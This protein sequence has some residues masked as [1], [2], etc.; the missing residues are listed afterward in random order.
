MHDMWNP[1]HGCLKKSEGCQNCYVY[2]FDKQKGKLG[3]QIYRT[4]GN[5]DYP[6]QKNR[7]GSYKVKSG[8]QLRVCMT[9]DFFLKEADIWRQEA[10]EIIKIRRDVVFFLITKRPERIERCLPEDWGDGWENV[11]LNVTAENQPRADE[12]VPILQELPFKHKGIMVTPFIGEVSL[13]KYLS[14]EKIEQVIVGGENYIE[15]RLLH[16][17]W[18]KNLYNECV[19]ADI[20]FIFYDIGSRFE[21]DGKIYCIQDSKRRK[22]LAIKSGLQ[23]SGKEIIFKLTQESQLE[24]FK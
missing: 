9:S 21:K 3:S 8:E 2:F 7:D 22:E 6:L 10:W 16:Y 15:A 18:V 12:R 13:K 14:S 17:Q 11:F 24:L 23:H 20:R 19:E 1:W 4:K 5:F